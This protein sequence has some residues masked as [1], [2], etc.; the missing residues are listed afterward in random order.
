[1]KKF[2]IIQTA[3]I[4]DVILATPVAEK[5]HRAF[6]DAAID[7]LVKKGNE[8]LFHRH[9][10]IREVI[11]WNKNDHKYPNFIRIIQKVRKN[12]YDSVIN[13]QRFASSGIITVLSGAG[14]TT[15]FRK[16]PLSFLFTKRAEHTIGDG[17]HETLRN[18]RLTADIPGDDLPRPVLY[19]SETDFTGIR[20]YQDSAYYTI[21]PTSIWFTKQYPMEKWIDFLGRIDKN[22]RVYFLGSRQDKDICNEIIERSGHSLSTNLAGELS[23]LE[24]AALMKGAKMNYTND[25]APMHLSSSVNAP[26]TVIFCSTVPAFGFGPLSDDSFI[27]ETTEHLDCR[28]CGLHGYRECPEKHFKCAL[29]ISTDQLVSRL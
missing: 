14:K 23:F 19:P 11:A 12:H 20:K 6:P 25:S 9:P 3:S 27:A 7:M 10:F 29:T 13:I 22:S 5:I 4:G 8:T 2:L 17:L 15:G 28:P 26:V 18:L 1:M 16:N 24:S 21:S